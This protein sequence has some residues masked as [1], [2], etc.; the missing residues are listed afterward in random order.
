M[1]RVVKEI[2]RAIVI[3]KCDK[4]RGSN[5]RIVQRDI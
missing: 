1:M 5:M 2:V 4:S 3:Q